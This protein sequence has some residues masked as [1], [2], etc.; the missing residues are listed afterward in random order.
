MIT[1]NGSRKF[2]NDFDLINM[3]LFD[4]SGRLVLA[5]SFE[6]T[7]QVSIPLMNL[8]QGSYFMRLSAGGQQRVTQ[9]LKL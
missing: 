1:Q 8:S 3:Q 5:D 9:L 6:E 7:T 4:I 2:L